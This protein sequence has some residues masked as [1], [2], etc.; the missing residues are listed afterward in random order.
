VQEI[1]AWIIA[2]ENA[3]RT[4][5]RSFRF[6]GHPRPE[7]IPNPKEW[8]QRESRDA[9]R[10][11]RYMPIVHNA[12]IADAARITVIIRKCPSFKTFVSEIRTWYPA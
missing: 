7:T 2:D 9:N 5:I 4:A 6:E 10:V 1:E 12:K 3:V 8:L 11:A